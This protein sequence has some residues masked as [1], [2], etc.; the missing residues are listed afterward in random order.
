MWLLKQRSVKT[1]S[2]NIYLLQTVDHLKIIEGS[3]LWC[4]SLSLATDTCLRSCLQELWR[5]FHRSYCNSL[6]LQHS[7]QTTK[8]PSK[9]VIV[10]SWKS[11]LPPPHPLSRPP[12]Y[13]SM[14]G[15]IRCV[16]C[17]KMCFGTNLY[18]HWPQKEEE[19]DWFHISK[20][21][22]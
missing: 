16:L 12:H 8:R 17:M 21:T 20:F 4:E 13:Y 10:E 1:W 6:S 2:I 14:K 11:K 9:L 15:M 7:R 3:C 5:C 19:K 22:Q 18:P